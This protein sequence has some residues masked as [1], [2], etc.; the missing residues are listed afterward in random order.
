MFRYTVRRL[1]G[2]LPVVFGISLLVFLMLRLIPGDPTT[3]ILGERSSPE[4]RARL[5]KELGLDRP[6]F[7]NFTGEGGVFN[8]QYF[9]FVGDFVRG[10]LG[11]SILRRRSVTTELSERF[12]ATAELT[13]AALLIATVLGVSMGILAATRRGSLLDA[14]TMF[15]ALFGV[16]IPI[17]WLGL[18]FQYFFAVN[19]HLLPISLR[20][21]PELSRGFQMITGFYTIDGLLHGRPDITLNALKHLVLPATALATV[22]LAIIAR[23]TRSAMLEVLHQDYIRTASAKGLTHRVVVIRHALRNALLPVVTIV[24]LQLGFLLGGAVLTETVFSWPGIGTWL[25]GGILGRDY[26]VVQG[27]VIV[28]ALIFVLVNL[29]VD[30]SYA[31]LDPRI[32]YH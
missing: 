10:D 2:L 19:R 27:G 12:P 4:Q 14:G 7:L 31:V 30:L 8:T 24:G 15:L 26:P 22:P 29:F 17:F 9:D 21:D 25:L 28:V 16:S 20:L 18:M 6:L 5:R 23:M 11:E 1:L 32:K 13:F 3:A